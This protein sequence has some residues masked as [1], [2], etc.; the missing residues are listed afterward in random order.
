MPEVEITT[1]HHVIACAYPW[2]NVAIPLSREAHGSQHG[3]MRNGRWYR[4]PQN[5]RAYGLK[6]AGWCNEYNIRYLS[7]FWS[8]DPRRP[9]LEHFESSLGVLSPQEL[10]QLRLIYMFTL[11]ASVDRIK[12]AVTS[13]AAALLGPTY[14]R[15]MDS[16]GVSRI[17]IMFWGEESATNSVAFQR[18]LNELRA[19]FK[20]RGGELFVITTHHIL[21]SQDDR[22]L[23]SVD[24][25][26]RHECY[27]NIDREGHNPAPLNTAQ[28]VAPT[29]Q[30]WLANRQQLQGKTQS[31]TGLPVYY[32]P[33]TMPSFW[34]PSSPERGKVVAQTR[35][36]VRSMFVA[37]RDDATT[38]CVRSG[39]AGLEIHKWAVL[40]SW[41]EWVEN[42]TIEPCFVRSNR[43]PEE[44]ASYGYDYGTDHLAQIRDIFKTTRRVLRSD[45]AE[46]LSAL[47][48]ALRHDRGVAD[49]V[50]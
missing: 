47:S 5:T 17:P 22:L 6:V 40:T 30:R 45:E 18:L 28:S 34:R 16:R 3:E 7:G 42:S 10:G 9:C 43:T 21:Q 11:Q 49:V 19:F 24:A 41:N 35:D 46:K 25:V 15:L 27:H 1:V 2:N 50:G 14:A 29:R 38:V 44:I 23:R 36:Q 4:L 48:G 20:E 13:R 37:L 39:T 8:G 33:G 31:A 12:E 26:Y 32:F